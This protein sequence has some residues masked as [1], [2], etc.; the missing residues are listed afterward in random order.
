VDRLF[1]TALRRVYSGWIDALIIVKPET[2]VSWHHAG[3]R[4]FW[5]WR[6]RQPGRPKVT[7]EIRELIRR[8]KA[9][10]PGWGAP[11]IHGELLQL[12]FNVSEPTVSRYL[13]HIRRRYDESQ[14]KQWLAFLNNHREV[15]AAFDFFTVPMLSFRTLYCFFVIEHGRRRILHFNCTEHPTGSWIVQQLREALSLPCPFRYALFDRDAKF[16]N[17]VLGFLKASGIEPVRTSLRS[18]WQNGIAERWVGSIRRELIDHVI[19]LNEQHLRRLGREYL[20]YYHEDRT[21]IM[22][23]KSTPATRVVVPRPTE[24]SEIRSQPRVGGLHH[25]Y[26]WTEAA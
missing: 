19:P 18:P 26:L 8:M 22:L 16:G 5:R 3:F 24:T 20:A 2:V 10:N 12:G 14:A 21:H 4:L 1:W 15:I 7:G 17:E 25:R 11:R 9:E 23:A 13:Q 6:S